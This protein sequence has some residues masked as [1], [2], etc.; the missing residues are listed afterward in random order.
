MARHQ[1]NVKAVGGI[2]LTVV[3]AVVAVVVVQRVFLRKDPRKLIEAGDRYYR[4]GELVIAAENYRTAMGLDPKDVETAIKFGDVVHRLVK[5]DETFQNEDRRAWDRVLTVDPVNRSALHRLLQLEIEV[6]ET[7]PNPTAFNRLHKLAETIKNLPING[8]DDKEKLSQS[9]L[10]DRARAY[11]HISVIASW[12]ADIVTPDSVVQE[13]TDALEKLLDEQIQNVMARGKSAGELNPDVAYYLCSSYVQQARNLRIK[14]EIARAREFEK[15]IESK[16]ESVIQAQPKNATLQLRYAQVLRNVSERISDDADDKDDRD[17][18]FKGIRKV[19]Q[20]ARENVRLEDPAMVDVYLTSAQF[21][22]RSRDVEGAERILRE[23][24]VRLPDDQRAR[25]ALAS[26]LHSNSKTRQEA[27]DLLKKPITDSGERAVGFIQSKTILERQTLAD[28]TSYQIDLF[29]ST[30][31]KEKRDE[32]EK[33]IRAN[34]AKLEKKVGMSSPVYKLKGRIA[35]MK[36]EKSAAVEAIPDLEKAVELFKQADASRQAHDWELEYFLA[37]AYFD[38]NQTGVARA[39]LA[40]ITRGVPNFVPARVIYCR[41]LINANEMAVARDELGIIQRLEPNNPQ[42][43]SLRMAIHYLDGTRITD[44]DIEEGLKKLPEKTIAEKRRKIP[45]AI[46]ANK[47]DLAIRLYEEIRAEL[48]ADIDTVRTLVQLYLSQE[49]KDLAE[50]VITEA[51]AKEPDNRALK[52]VRA[53]MNKD[54]K[55]VYELTRDGIAEVKDTFQRELSFFDFYTANT[56]PV[57]AAK[58]LD[59]AEKADPEN[60]KVMDIKFSL[61][62]QSRDWPTAEIYSDRLGVKNMDEARG[63]IYKYRLALVQG[64]IK[65]AEGFAKRLVSELPQYARSYLCYGDI[66]K[67]QQMY[68][69]ASS[70]YRIALQKQSENMEAFRGLVECY[71]GMKKPIEAMSAIKEALDRSP[72]DNY[73]REQQIGWELNYGDPTKALEYRKGTAERT[74]DSLGAQLAYAA[75]QWQVANYFM[76]KNNIPN[77]EKYRD[78]AKGKFRE[79]ITKW[80]DERL[81]YAYMADISTNLG[82]FE[83]GE[84]VLKELAARDKWKD[85]SEGKLMLGDYFARFN[86]VKEA[87]EYYVDGIAKLENKKDAASIDVI[88]KIAAFYA[89]SK[90][91][92]KA[93]NL[94]RSMLPDRRVEQQLLEVLLSDNKLTEADSI[95]NAR[96]KENPTDGSALA[97]RAF[98]FIQRKKNPEAL[99]MLDQ[100]ISID[101]AN[102]VALYYRGMIRFREGPKSIELALKD[103][104]AARDC[105]EDPKAN[106]TI[107]AQIQTRLALAEALR[108]HNQV[109]DAVSELEMCVKMQPGNKDIRIHLI[110]MLSTLAQPRWS[111]VE[112]LIKEAQKMPEF[113]KDA[114]WYKLMSNRWVSGNQP[115]KALEAI[116]QAI[117]LCSGDANRI[118]PMMQDY[119]N[120]LIKLKKYRETV[121]EAT[122]LL[123]NQELSK[124]GWWVYNLRGNALTYLEGKRSE[125]LVDFDHALEITAKLRND[126]ATMLVIQTVSDTIGKE[127]AIRRCKKE[128]EKNEANSNHWRVILTYLYFAKQDYSSAQKEIETVLND[129]GKLSDAEK[130]TTYA[131][132]GS[133]YMLSND[134]KRAQIMYEKLLVASESLHK[135]PDT[136]ALNNLAM[137]WA[138]LLDK[139]DV[140]KALGYS[141]KAVSIMD[142]V[143]LQDPNIQDTHGWMLILNG[144]TTEGISYVQS[145]LTRKPNI[146]EAH[147]HLGV[148]YLAQKLGLEAQAEFEKTRKFLEDRKNK[149]LPYDIKME[150]KLNKGMAEAKQLIESGANTGEPK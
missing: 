123:Q 116:R 72:G 106:V 149:A 10:R 92:E 111:K 37:M 143:G 119:L 80:P 50:K 32:I 34:Y 53:Q 142:S 148:A 75:A 117:T 59:L 51:L 138:E 19:L 103:L 88:R 70:Q 104:T 66:L 1:V 23:L 100:A 105:A 130:E 28:L 134:Y 115:E 135:T 128:A 69:E 42:I 137:L 76:G 118:L 2:L 79:I 85:R 43:E 82:D 8:K 64:N 110:E 46:S 16:F 144:R 22:Q 5:N 136:T 29:V 24:C 57:E 95:L 91:A 113:A 35:L 84:K 62:L 67:E 68:E 17:L 39:K 20:D 58:H 86:K 139:P 114:D 41:L 81:A 27:V 150:V 101:P 102:Q 87:E 55:A 44:K 126:D 25:L 56:E 48:P 31:E 121:A 146:T 60:T 129:M 26:L 112:S 73:F 45:V 12:L 109:D 96:L 33:E 99:E 40:E 94:L 127:E 54:T 131:F 6:L 107:G 47:F 61:A 36:G 147:Y 63:L 78:A 30:S 83:G 13:N 11:F 14:G 145:A 3:L 74:P 21:M 124:N 90:Q 98:L 97:T 132:A 108:A 77:F 93:A 141:E 49:K 38:S 125:A 133:V 140:K 89:N 71:Y 15:K 120:I 4:A 9:D 122:S 7:Q 52:V 65:K 18:R